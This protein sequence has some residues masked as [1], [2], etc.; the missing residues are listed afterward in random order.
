MKEE[1]TEHN[2]EYMVSKRFLAKVDDLIEEN[3]MV[4]VLSP[5][6]LKLLLQIRKHC[7]LRFAQE[8]SDLMAV[9]YQYT[10]ADEKEA[11]E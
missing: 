4:C 10:S 6:Y 2:N 9:G 1:W 5:S 3:H 11:A 7:A 8:E